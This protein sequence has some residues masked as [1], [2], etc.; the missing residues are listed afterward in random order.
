M[1]V[2]RFN[3]QVAAM[4]CGDKFKFLLDIGEA[5]PTSYEIPA[6]R[7]AGFLLWAGLNEDW[8]RHLDIFS[9]KLKAAC[10][11]P[12]HHLGVQAG[13][14]KA[15]GVT[16]MGISHWCEGHSTPTRSQAEKIAE[17]LGWDK[18]QVMSLYDAQILARTMRRH[19][20]RK[21]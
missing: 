21:V 8:S 12:G 20:G 19:Q 16:I 3:S 13:L 17:I 10:C 4:K 14:A 15:L 18:D 9:N 2:Y 6:E 5:P 1:G 7:I 11:S